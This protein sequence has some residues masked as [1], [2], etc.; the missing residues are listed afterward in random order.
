MGPNN[1]GSGRH[2]FGLKAKAERPKSPQKKFD[3]NDLFVRLPCSDLASCL[4]KYAMK[5]P[6]LINM[7]KKSPCV[8]QW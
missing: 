7:I 5:T 3:E 8:C 1:Q 4:G 6:W 2:C